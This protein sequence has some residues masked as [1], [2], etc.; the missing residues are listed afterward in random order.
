MKSK[1]AR[2]AARAQVVIAA[3]TFPAAIVVGSI[4]TLFFGWEAAAITTV[5]IVAAAGFTSSLFIPVAGLVIS[6]CWFG[7]SG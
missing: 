6:W 2:V 5:G 7:E 4:G 3:G 1:V